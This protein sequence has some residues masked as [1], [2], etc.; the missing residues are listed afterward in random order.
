V[1]VSVCWIEDEVTANDEHPLI[2]PTT[3]QGD[4]RW[5]GEG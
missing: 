5:C 2:V 1:G 3:G 4:V